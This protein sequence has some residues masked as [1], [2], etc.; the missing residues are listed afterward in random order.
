MP[1]ASASLLR[2]TGAEAK[3]GTA[4]EAAGA[5]TEVPKARRGARGEEEPI[6]GEG[7]M[8]EEAQ[9]AIG[10]CGGEM[11]WNSLKVL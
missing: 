3:V 1:E 6:R 8:V 7:V 2:S 9:D 5:G 4:A 10:D 11:F